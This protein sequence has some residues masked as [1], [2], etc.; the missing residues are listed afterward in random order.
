MYCSNCGIELASDFKFCSSCGH[1]ITAHGYNSEHSKQA[2]SSVEGIGIVSLKVDSQPFL[3][4]LEKIEIY[5]NGALYEKTYKFGNKD[6]FSLPIG[7]YDIYAVCKV[8]LIK[9]TSN[10]LSLTL[11]E[12]Q[13]TGLFIEYNNF[14][15]GIKLIHSD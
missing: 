7:T 15:G 13:A 3:L 8:P 12:N 11:K 6:K 1:S 10:T 5:I 2:A 14:T 9:R 4:P